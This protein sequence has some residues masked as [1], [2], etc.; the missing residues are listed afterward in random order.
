VGF[1]VTDE[2]SFFTVRMCTVSLR[3]ALKHYV[4]LLLR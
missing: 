3:K 4:A 2:S 1:V